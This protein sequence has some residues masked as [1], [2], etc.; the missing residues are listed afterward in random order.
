MKRHAAE[1]IRDR[2]ATRLRLADRVSSLLAGREKNG[3]QIPHWPVER[4][5]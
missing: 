3:R 1:V 5:P 4:S 2:I